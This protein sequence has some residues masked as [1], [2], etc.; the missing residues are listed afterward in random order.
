M[1]TQVLKYEEML[2][3]WVVSEW[4]Q[5]IAYGISEQT[6]AE[7]FS[8]LV[9]PEERQ[10]DTLFSIEDLIIYRE[11]LLASKN[12]DGTERLI[13]EDEKNLALISALAEFLEKFITAQSMHTQDRSIMIR[14]K[15]D[16]RLP[17]DLYQWA[18]NLLE[19]RSI[20][21]TGKVNSQTGYI[22]LVIE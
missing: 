11:K 9:K 10:R 17:F 2:T 7:V 16:R 14:I 4:D 18:V 3:V 19:K 20:I 15:M 22:T 8:L 12:L 1:V 6:Q 5:Y 21:D 13:Q